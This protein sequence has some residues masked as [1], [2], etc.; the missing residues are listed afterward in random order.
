MA[1][2]PDNPLVSELFKAVH[3]KKDKGGKGMKRR[4]WKDFFLYQL[5]A[6]QLIVIVPQDCNLFL[7][8]LAR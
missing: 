1:K 5:E 8:L 4:G 2:L 7:W 6:Q 3:G